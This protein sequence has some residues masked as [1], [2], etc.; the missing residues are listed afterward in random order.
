MK[1]V[2]WLVLILFLASLSFAQLSVQIAPERNA[3]NAS[4]SLDLAFG[5]SSSRPICG[6]VL[7]ARHEQELAAYVAKHPEAISRSLSK[8]G[9][10]GFSVG[11]T[12]AW[13]AHDYTLS[14]EYLTNS[15]CR[16]VGNN[17]YI[18]VEDSMWTS[19]RVTQSVVDSVRTAFDSRV[20]ANPSQGVYQ[21]D[22]D[23]FGV[24]PDV[25]SD[26][27]IIILLLDI[28][29]GYDGSGGYVVGYFYG[30][31]ELANG[32]GVVGSNQAEIYY[33]DANPLDLLSSNG[34][35]VGMSTTAHEFQH[36]IHWNSN[37]NEITFINEGCSLVAEVNC[38][39][40]IF[41][42]GYFADEP[43]HYLLDWRS[44]NPT[45][46]FNDYSRAARFFTYLRD[47]FTMSIFK[48]IVQSLGQI[49]IGTLQYALGLTG[50]GRDFSGVFV[51]WAIA[52]TLDDRT[53]NTKYGYNYPGLAK[54][55]AYVTLNPNLPPSPVTVAPLGTFY[56]TFNGGSSLKVTETSTGG[57]LIPT[58]VKL[59]SPN[60]IGAMS[61]GV[62]LSEPDFGSGYKTVTVVLANQ[63]F[64]DS[65]HVILQAAGKAPPA[66]E[67]AWDTGEPVGYLS[68]MGGD[69]VCVV[70]DGSGSGAQLDSFRVAVRRANSITGGVWSFGTGLHPLGALLSPELTITGKTDS[71]L[72]QSIPPKY[73]APWPNWVTVDLHSL[74]VDASNPFAVGFA[75][76]GVG[77]VDQRLMIVKEPLSG[78]V[79]SFAYYNE[80]ENTGSAVGWYYLTIA[81]DP[82]NYWGYMVR[83]YVSFA[84]ATGVRQSKELPPDKFQLDQNYPN[85][86]NPSTRIA[87]QTPTAG[88]VRL[89]VYDAL[90]R[91]V[92]TLV[93]ETLGAG[94]HVATWL[95]LTID[96]GVAASGVYFYRLEVDGKRLTRSMILMK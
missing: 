76:Q 55:A 48:N 20:P 32:G 95:G 21:T 88:H 41:D 13:Y 67:L 92:V 25:D 59:G 2:G 51:D 69:S 65:A 26:P 36:M 30:L 72:D 64:T 45:L 71:L 18:F 6:S 23:A 84:G 49:G 53:V 11:S 38:G 44:N 94:S 27:K 1:R 47:Q 4:A 33:L 14:N 31:N 7:L 91:E 70:F 82:V 50:T 9:S 63:S 56:V 66:I 89:V 68:L 86:F 75:Y 5:K 61:N 39:Y 62:E 29:D 37:M 16:A 24:P 79:H 85:P 42:Q 8:T 57:Q 12:H 87:Y 35:A 74:H 78:G 93:D 80:A 43:N 90:G 96:G 19:G 58:A 15:T 83:A 73:L 77:T 10:W 22:V 40:P 34:L 46:A 17:C 60:A 81:N 52:N 28:R 3:S 54:P